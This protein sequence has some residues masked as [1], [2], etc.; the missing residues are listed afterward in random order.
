MFKLSFSFFISKAKGILPLPN[1]GGVTKC[2]RQLRRGEAVLLFTLI[3][4]APSLACTNFLVG[5]NASAD[6]STMITY[7]RKV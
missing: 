4:L 3:S 6:G 1:R 2:H 7:S 5:K